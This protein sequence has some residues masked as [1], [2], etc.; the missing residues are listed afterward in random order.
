MYNKR[1]NYFKRL[2]NLKAYLK[3]YKKISFSLLCIFVLCAA[4]VL[5]IHSSAEIHNLEN[6]TYVESNSQS[7]TT[8]QYYTRSESSTNDAYIINDHNNITSVKV[9]T[10]KN[11][12]GVENGTITPNTNYLKIKV[13][14]KDIHADVLETQYNCSFRYNLPEFFRSISTTERPIVDK[15]NR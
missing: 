12:E 7:T 1:T 4:Y 10:D 6:Y 13:E 3:K 5:T 8:M 2:G 11:S 14:F 15:N 9:S